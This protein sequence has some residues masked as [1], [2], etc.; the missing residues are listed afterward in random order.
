MQA[1]V[2]GSFVVSLLIICSSTFY[3][4]YNIQY[5]QGWDSCKGTYAQ[6]LADTCGYTYTEVARAT[7]PH[8]DFVTTVLGALSRVQWDINSC[9]H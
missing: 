1:P 2:L 6:Q 5:C 4:A 9:I 7:A 8:R 3:Y